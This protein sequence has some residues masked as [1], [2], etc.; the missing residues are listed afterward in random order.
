MFRTLANFAFDVVAQGLS[1]KVVGALEKEDVVKT[2]EKV[3]GVLEP[4][5]ILDPL[6]YCS[7]CA[8]DPVPVANL[9]KIHVKPGCCCQCDQPIKGKK[10]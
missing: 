2:K 10:F 3:P 1:A 6:L 7:D 9:I 4:A 8:K 5:E